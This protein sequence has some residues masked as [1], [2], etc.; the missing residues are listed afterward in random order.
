MTSQEIELVLSNIED[1]KKLP[2]QLSLGFVRS[3]AL[4]NEFRVNM[5]L[6]YA[7]QNEKD[8]VYPSIADSNEF[9]KKFFEKMTEEEYLNYLE[10]H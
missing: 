4:P 9:V 1:Y 5:H 3:A 6:A 2:E 7:L 10:T 8:G